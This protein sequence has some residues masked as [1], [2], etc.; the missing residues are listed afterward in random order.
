[1]QYP[2]AGS[3]RIACPGCFFGVQHQLVNRGQGLDGAAPG[4]AAD[5]GV[6]DNPPV[7][8]EVGRDVGKDPVVAAIPG[9]VLD[10][11]EE[12][13]AGLDRVPGQLEGR[14]RHIR[15]ADDVVLAADQ[16]VFAVTG[17]LDEDRIAIGDD[18]FAVGLGDDEVAF[19]HQ[20]FGRG[21]LNGLV[22]HNGF[23]S[24][25]LAKPARGGKIERAK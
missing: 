4:A 7:L 16:F 3:N 21:G 11:G 1:M 18:A 13:L 5:R 23:L 10:V 25:G 17:K 8:V 12:L 19:P 9:Q 2:A 22:F 24:P 14:T 20:A 15:V 6:A